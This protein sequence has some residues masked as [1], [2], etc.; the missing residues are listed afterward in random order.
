MKEEKKEEK[1]FEQKVEDKYGKGSFFRLSD[2]KIEKYNVDNYISTGSRCLNEVLSGNSKCGIPKGHITELYGPE[3]AGKSTIGLHISAQA[4]KDGIKAGY[5]DMENGIDLSYAKKI[6]VNESL[7][8]LGHPFCCEDSFEMAE[9]LIRNNFP[10]IIFDSVDSMVPRAIIEASMDESHMGVHARKM[11]QGLRKHSKLIGR[12]N[13]TSLFINQIRMKIGGYGNPETT[14]GGIALKFYA[15]IRVEIRAPRGGKT[16]EKLVSKGTLDDIISEE[17]IKEIKKK[18]KKEEKPKE[19]VVETGTTVKLKTTK[20][21]VF[22]P[23]RSCYLNIVY[24]KGID[25]EQDLIRYFASHNVI[26]LEGGEE[27]EIKSIRYP[28]GSKN[29]TRVSNFLKKLKNKDFKKKIKEELS[30]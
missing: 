5:L 11:G 21:K 10:L 13:A 4:N 3:G 17:D 2:K 12:M 7:F 15:F 30:V 19:K 16:V 23:Y 24:G 27:K 28:I 9:D 14:T 26:K 18:K 20:N 29:K 1:T 25:K 8:Y 6:G 22:D